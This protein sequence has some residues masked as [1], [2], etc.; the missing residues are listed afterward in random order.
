MANPEP[1]GKLTVRA[2]PSSDCAREL[3]SRAPRDGWAAVTRF[4]T[5][6]HL[7]WSS[8]GSVTA[9]V[10][11][12]AD[13]ATAAAEGLAGSAGEAE[14]GAGAGAG[15]AGADEAGAADTGEAGSGAPGTSYA[16]GTSR[17]GVDPE[18]EAAPRPASDADDA[19]PEG[20]A[21]ACGAGAFSR[22]GT[23]PGR[24][25]ASRRAATADADEVPSE[26][27]GAP[28]EAVTPCDAPR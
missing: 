8:P 17:E 20:L 19:E 18:P 27:T 14:A 1:A 2:L 12:A 22:T 11:A 16:A 26:A 21:A 15:A 4:T 6:A 7:R 23:A 13:A 3:C 10:D 25:P 9:G 24:E 28:A 5:S